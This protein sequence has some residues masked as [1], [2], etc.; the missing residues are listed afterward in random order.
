MLQTAF[1][2]GSSGGFAAS[3][4]ASVARL[5]SDPAST[6]SAGL[7]SLASAVLPSRGVDASPVPASVLIHEAGFVHR[8]VKPGNVFVCRDGTLKLLDFGLVRPLEPGDGLSFETDAGI[9]VG[10][11]GYMAPEQLLGNGPVD[12]RADQFAW[13]VLA[14]E[15]LGGR[16]PATTCAA[17]GRMLGLLVEH[18]LSLMEVEPQVGAQRAHVIM[19][20][21]AKDPDNRWRDMR[22]ALDRF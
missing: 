8:D 22:E 10:T 18:P 1:V 15:I 11:R 6:G 20:A 14:Y 13:G 7:A 12:G 3:A 5:P 9:V 21:L 19:R 2:H 16:H 4:A 17:G